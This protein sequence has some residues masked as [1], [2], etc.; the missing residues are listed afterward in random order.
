MPRGVYDRSKVKSTKSGRKL[1]A[2]AKQALVHAKKTRNHPGVH[3]DQIPTI[4]RSQL[5][6][7]EITTRPS[8]EPIG[9]K[10]VDVRRGDTITIRII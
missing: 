1:I 10:V 3:D 4:D 9:S 6:R 7:S 2:A 5:V 8:A